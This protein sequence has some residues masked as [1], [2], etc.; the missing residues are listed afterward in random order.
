MNLG[1]GILERMCKIP[2]PQEGCTAV[3]RGIQQFLRLPGRHHKV[4]F[5]RDDLDAGAIRR[6]MPD[7]II[8]CR[9]AQR[10]NAARR[11][12]D[13]HGVVLASRP[14]GVQQDDAAHGHPI[15]KAARV[16]QC[17]QMRHDLAVIG[18]DGHE[19]AGAAGQAIAAVVIHVDVVAEIAEILQLAHDLT[20][21]HG[22]A[23][24][25]Q[26]IS[27]GLAADQLV[28]AQFPAV[29]GLESQALDVRDAD[30]APGV[31]C[32]GHAPE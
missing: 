29:A 10:R 18:D 13:D 17:V 32:A 19:S 16:A 22:I 4:T 31:G 8:A 9:A 20:S 7:R 1:A 30:K 24:R 5:A 27:S 26:Q 12:V 6:Q 11:G 23:R 28:A 2:L 15:K 21:E 25:H 3:L 14:H